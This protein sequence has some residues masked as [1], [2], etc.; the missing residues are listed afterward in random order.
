M[1]T[2]NTETLKLSDQITVSF[3]DKGCD[4]Y[5][6]DDKDARNI[7]LVTVKYNGSKTSFTFGDSIANTEDSK[8]PFNKEHF[9]EYKTDILECITSDYYY[10]KDYYPDLQSFCDEFG[11]DIDSRKAEGIYKKCLRQSEKL[12]KL[13]NDTDIETLRKELDN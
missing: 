4:H 7:Y 8:N 11:Y 12:H 6:P 13:F 10:S 9:D 3:K 2:V 5:F 1:T